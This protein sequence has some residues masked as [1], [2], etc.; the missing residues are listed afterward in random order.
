LSLSGTACSAS[1]SPAI[2]RQAANTTASRIISAPSKLSRIP[3]NVRKMSS[4][5]IILNDKTRFPKLSFFH[6]HTT[7]IDTRVGK[8]EAFGDHEFGG[9]GVHKRRSRHR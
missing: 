9:M 2:R 7:Q 5:V 1:A 8:P 4:I 6:D 3:G